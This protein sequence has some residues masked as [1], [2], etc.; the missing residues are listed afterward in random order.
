MSFICSPIYVKHCIFHPP[1]RTLWE[2]FYRFCVFPIAL[3][4]ISISLQNFSFSPHLKV[5]YLL[6][7]NIH[8]RHSHLY[9][10][11]S[12]PWGKIF[13]VWNFCLWFQCS[14][15]KSSKS[16][17]STSSRSGLAF[18]EK[19]YKNSYFCIYRFSPRPGGKF[20]QLSN[21]SLWFGLSLYKTNFSFPPHSEVG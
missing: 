12:N 6:W 10:R 17:P 4:H 9:R 13:Q 11:I 2:K 5:G 16:Q 1:F 19:T 21:F 8:Y 15:Y 14:F 20:F 7:T 18:L 3:G